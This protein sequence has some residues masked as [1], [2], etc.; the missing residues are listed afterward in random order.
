MR[1][2][3]DTDTAGDDVFSILLALRQPDVRLEALTIC[4]GNVGF[5]QQ[6]ENALY[7]LEQAGRSWDVPVYPG[8]PLPMLRKPVDAA[9]VFGKDGMSNANFPK[10]RQRPEGRHAVDAIVDLVMQNPGEIT[11]LAQAPL[12]N[13]AVA[14]LKEPRIAQALRHLWIM[15]GTDNAIGNV[16]P[17]AEFNFYVDPEAARIV[18]NA[19]FRVTLSTWTLTMK[20]GVLLPDDFAEI[21]RMDTPL[22]RFFLQVNKATL[23]YTRDRHR[24][25]LSTHPDSLTCACMLD[26][27]VILEA[28]DCEVDVETAGEITR[29]YSSVSSPQLP[30]H[31]LAD[32]DL[33]RRP[34][35]ARVIK[36]ADTARFGQ[37]LR[38][39]LR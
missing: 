3:I 37:M 25:A 12:T 15:G 24:A 29:G 4:N 2:I 31:D 8:C 34:H 21:E 18:L 1:L 36:T 14:Y 16:T 20:S 26:E 13:I 7:T 9:Y 5:E 22:S 39:A 17:A 30:D 27:S 32:P 28:A 6:V 19:G 33:I 10:A 38:T 23:D 35:N 11:L